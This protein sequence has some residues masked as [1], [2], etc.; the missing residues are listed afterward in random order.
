[1]PC[2]HVHPFV[3]SNY[4]HA[5][6]VV[7]RLY[8]SFTEPGESFSSSPA[9]GEAGELGKDSHYYV[10]V[11]AMGALFLPLIVESFGLW[12]PNSIL[13]LRTIASKS[14]LLSGVPRGVAISNLM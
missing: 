7:T 13:L 3:N 11:S 2:L 10:R 8:F 9:V 4:S 1:M 12:T 5:L 6:T 14:I